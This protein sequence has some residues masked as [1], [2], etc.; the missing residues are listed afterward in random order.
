MKPETGVLLREL[1]SNGEVSFEAR[2]GRGGY[3][4]RWPRLA[5][6]HI[7]KRKQRV[8]VIPERGSPRASLAPIRRIARAYAVS[9]GGRQPLHATVLTG[10]GGTLALLGTPG[11]GK[12][13]L[14]LAMLD[15]G[16][17]LVTDDVLFYRTHSRAIRPVL[18]LPML[19][20]RPDGIAPF[21]KFPSIPP[22][23]LRGKPRYDPRYGKLMIPLPKISHGGKIDVFV[24]LRRSRKGHISGR[25]LSPS[26]STLN[27]IVAMFNGAL[28][29]RRVRIRQILEAASLASKVP[30]WELRYP[31]G[32]RHLKRVPEALQGILRQTQEGRSRD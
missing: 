8:T 4:L 27:L 6:V 21:P 20:V 31:T 3:R 30:V 7:T 10:H 12:S 2:E 15:E 23:R 11:A 5:T 25:R 14:A 32:K 9:L 16:W 26:Q 13:T 22:L 1:D 28:R 19:K 17:R 24:R 29:P 18:R